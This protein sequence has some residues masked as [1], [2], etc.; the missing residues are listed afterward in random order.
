MRARDAVVRPKPIQKPFRPL[1]VA[2][3]KKFLISSLPRWG[4]GWYTSRSITRGDSSKGYVLTGEDYAAKVDWINESCRSRGIDPESVDRGLLLSI[5]IG[6]S[7]SELDKKIERS[8]LGSPIKHYRSMPSEVY[9][10]FLL[11]GTPDKIRNVVEG[12]IKLG[13]SDF[14][15]TF[16]DIEY[17]ENDFESVELFGKKVIESIKSKYR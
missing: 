14:L 7:E 12:Y 15:V 11:T 10:E 16:R 2:A 8:R 6:E 9:R 3:S 4:A 1:S 5:V 13:V 17:D